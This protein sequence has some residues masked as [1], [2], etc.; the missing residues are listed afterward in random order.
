MSYDVCLCGLEDV[1][2]RNEF[3]EK[4]SSDISVLDTFEKKV[5]RRSGKELAATIARQIGL[6]SECN[7]IV[8]Y[9]NEK[10]NGM[11]G[12]IDL[13]D[14][15]G[16]QKPIIVCLDGKVKNEHEMRRYCEFRGIQMVDNL[17]E[18]I[19]EVEEYAGQ[20]E[21]ASVVV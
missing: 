12:L 10:W 4:I 20:I 18:L 8:F 17:D 19:T 15:I 16:Q 13:G 3:K 1:A 21:L 9:F 7:I 11:H 2:W 14:C 6:V 5:N